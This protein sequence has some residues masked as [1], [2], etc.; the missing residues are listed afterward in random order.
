MEH[1]V[2]QQLKAYLDEQQVLSS[3]PHGFRSKRSCC[4]ALLTISN[5]L[6]AAKNDGRFSAI[7]AL[8]YTRAFDTINHEILLPKLAAINFDY[9]SLSWFSSYLSGRQ[10]YISYNS[11]QSD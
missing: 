5:N 7:A 3:A 2:H 6:S 11:A 9:S 4:S 8:D 1:I 10:Q